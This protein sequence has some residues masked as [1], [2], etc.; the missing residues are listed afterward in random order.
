MLHV[1][2]LNV[3]GYRDQKKIIF[4]T[5]RDVFKTRDIQHIKDSTFYLDEDPSSMLLWINENLPIEYKDF[6]DLIK[7][8]DALSKADVFLGRTRR[9][10]NYE[11]WSYAS[12]IMTGRVAT[13]KTHNYPNAEY[14]F[15][16]WLREFKN[17][18]SQRDIRDSIINKISDICHNSN[19]KTRNFLLV[20]FIPMFKNNTEFAV[21]MKNEFDFTEIEIKYL[22]G[23]TDSNKLKD[24]LSINKAVNIKTFEKETYNYNKRE[25]KQQSLLDF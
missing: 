7:G 10:Q 18:K 15:P 1:Q 24:I 5:L 9:R 21:K 6:N 12:D 25:K 14:N 16:R 8:Y 11:L 17:S 19:R 4:E 20:Y 13:A 3:L 2:S 23:K 22:L